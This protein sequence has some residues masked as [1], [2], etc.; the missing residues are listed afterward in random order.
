MSTQ[1]HIAIPGAIM[2]ADLRPFTKMIYGEILSLSYYTEYCW[3]S[4]KF[5]AVK[6]DRTTRTVTRALNQLE[7]AGFI[8]MEVRKD[9]VNGTSKRKIFITNKEYYKLIPREAS[10]TFPTEKELLDTNVY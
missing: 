6:F 3:A 9:N 7:K 5:W 2:S 4:N 10:Q 8:T 1:Y